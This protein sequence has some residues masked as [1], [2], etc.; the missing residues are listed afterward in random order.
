MP[1]QEQ[2]DD[3][4]QRLVLYIVEHTGLCRSD[5]EHVIGYE[6]RFWVERPGLMAAMMGMHDDED[7]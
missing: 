5:V 7:S 4:W 2:L 6:C 1:T 3:V